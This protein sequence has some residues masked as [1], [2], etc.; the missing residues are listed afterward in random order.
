MKEHIDQARLAVYHGRMEDTEKEAILKQWRN[1]KCL[2]MIAT[3]SFGMGMHMPDVRHV[4]HYVFPMSMSRWS[5]IGMLPERMK[6]T[7]MLFLRS[8][9]SGKWTC[10]P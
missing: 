5:I 8:T 6:L 10:W 2:T 9:D 3:S 1:G 4:V 7:C